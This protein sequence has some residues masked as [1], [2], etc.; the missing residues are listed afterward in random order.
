MSADNPPDNDKDEAFVEMG[1]DP[2]QPHPKAPWWHPDEMGDRAF[3]A[4][5]MMVFPHNWRIGTFTEDGVNEEHREGIVIAVFGYSA[6][7]ATIRTE[8]ILMPYA[9][10]YTLAQGLIANL[11]DDVKRLVI[12]ERVKEVVTHLKAGE[13]DTPPSMEVRSTEYRNIAQKIIDAEYER[14][15]RE[16][17]QGGQESGDPE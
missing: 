17:A 5:Q 10:S 7:D 14:Q 11:P 6:M 1:F 9:M 16:Q 4:E 2:S 8:M 15:Q 3:L 12:M 13:N